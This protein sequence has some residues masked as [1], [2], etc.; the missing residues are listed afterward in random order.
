MCLVREDVCTEVSRC[1]LSYHHN[2]ADLIIHSLIV[3]L[4]PYCV[5]PNFWDWDTVEIHCQ[6]S[7]NTFSK[8]SESYPTSNADHSLLTCRSFV[9]Q[10]LSEVYYSLDRYEGLFRPRSPRGN[11]GGCFEK[12][13]FFIVKTNNRGERY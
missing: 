10:S 13:Y 1:L 4:S 11:P 6:A 9:F 3:T 8:K 2:R 5:S 12:R 7:V